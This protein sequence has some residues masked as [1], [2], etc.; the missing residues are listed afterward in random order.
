MPANRL[1]WNYL[2]SFNNLWKFWFSSNDWNYL[3]QSYLSILT[4]VELVSQTKLHVSVY[5]FVSLYLCSTIDWIFFFRG[6][7][8][9]PFRHCWGG[10]KHKKLTSVTNPREAGILGSYIP[11]FFENGLTFYQEFFV[12][13]FLVSLRYKKSQRGT[14]CWESFWVISGLILLYVPIFL[15]KRSIFFQEILYRCSW[16][17][18]TV[19]TLLFFFVSCPPATHSGVRFSISWESFNICSWNFVSMFAALIW[20]SLH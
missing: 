19:T 17:T 7:G 20:W 14:L 1:K 5:L 4:S 9:G 15:E 8:Y 6:F 13:L 2:W 18:L 12:K 10:H 3:N 16:Y 11:H